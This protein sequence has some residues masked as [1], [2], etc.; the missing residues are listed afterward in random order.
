LAPT[1]ERE[2]ASPTS[3]PPT[4]KEKGLEKGTKS[5]DNLITAL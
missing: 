5:P 3:Q 4:L 2:D 1:L